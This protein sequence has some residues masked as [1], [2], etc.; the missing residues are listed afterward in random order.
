MCVKCTH[1]NTHRHTSYHILVPFILIIAVERTHLIFIKVISIKYISLKGWTV[2]NITSKILPGYFLPCSQKKNMLKCC[3]YP[4]SSCQWFDKLT[5][6]S[7]T[8]T[9]VLNKIWY[10][11]GRIHLAHSASLYPL[12]IAVFLR[13]YRQRDLKWVRASFLAVFLIWH[14]QI[15]RPL[16]IAMIGRR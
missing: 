14:H 2:R 8:V 7:N 1:T 4:I 6:P 12:N 10:K 9:Q 3:H 15:W 16:I 5:L 13:C 11:T